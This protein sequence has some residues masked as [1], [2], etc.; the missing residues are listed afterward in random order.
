MIKLMKFRAYTTGDRV[1]LDWKNLKT[2][3]PAIKLHAKQQGPF[4][5]TNVISH[6]AYQ[7]DLPKNLKIHNVFHASLLSP[8]K[9]T[10]DHGPNF[11]EPPPDLVDGEEEWEVKKVLDARLFRCKRQ[12]QY[13][14]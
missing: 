7:L 14:V 8:Y 4:T 2:S 12:Q 3:H 13:K 6:V 10:K 1:W 5:I 11:T 9:E